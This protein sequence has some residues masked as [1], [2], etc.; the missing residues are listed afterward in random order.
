MAAENSGEAYPLFVTQWEDDPSQFG[1]TDWEN[2][3]F[4]QATEQKH[5]ISVS[6]SGENYNFYIVFRI[7]K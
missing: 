2:E 3:M 1:N 5:E 6:K 7:Q 4:R